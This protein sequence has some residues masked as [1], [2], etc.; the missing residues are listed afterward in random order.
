[1]WDSD[2]LGSENVLHVV[3]KQSPQFLD[4]I[5]TDSGDLETLQELEDMA[6]RHPDPEYVDYPGPLYRVNLYH[7][8][9]MEGAAMVVSMNH[10]IIDAS[11]SQTIQEDLDRV[12]GAASKNPS[13]TATALLSELE[14]HVDYKAWADSHYNLRTSIEARA[15]TRW[16][17]KRLKSLA[18]HVKAGALFPSTPRSGEAVR[19]RRGQEPVPVQVDVPGFQTLRREYPQITAT[20]VVRAAIALANVYRTGYSHAAFGNL[21]AARTYFPFLPKSV[22]EQAN[23]G[24]QFEAT[25]VGGPTYQMVFNLVE[26]NK[27]GR[28]TVAQFLQRM[29]DEQTANTKYASAPL[30]EIMKGLDEVSPG[31][32][33]LLPRLID[34]QHLNWR[35]GLGTTGTNPFQHSKLLDTVVRPVTGLTWHAGLGGPQSQTLFMLVY[36][37]GARVTGQDAARMGEVAVAITKW[38]TTKENWTQPVIEYRNAL[39]DV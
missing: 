20:A 6:T 17:V 24:H 37:D 39:T 22:I 2:I 13:A 1:M 9:E 36:G 32:G 35:P 19:S 14:P 4:L 23:D 12:L 34:T 5:V 28:E 30:K 27:R 29:Q 33:E 31:S 3:M 8:K 10:S 25:D 16:H 18:E 15:A 21:E 7:V 26:V 38:L 11:L